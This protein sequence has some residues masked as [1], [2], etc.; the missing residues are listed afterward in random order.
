LAAL[1]LVTILVMSMVGCS[2]RDL[3]VDPKPD[4]RALGFSAPGD[5]TPKPHPT[6]P[7][8][9]TISYPVHFVSADSTAAGSTGTSRWLLG[10]AERKPVDMTW[11]LTA[12]PSWPGFP[13]QGVQHIGPA[14]S[15]TL[16]VG[17][18]VPA[19]AASGFY[20]LSMTVSTT[21]TTTYTDY[22]T[23]RVFGN[24]PPPT[25]PPTPAVAFAGSDSVPP[26]S[27]A[28][29]GWQL[30]NE[31]NHPFTMTWTLSTGSQWP[32]FPT[33]G[34]VNLAAQQQ[35]FILVDVA[36]PD[37]AVVGLRSIEMTVT[38]P[39]SLPP[40]SSPGWIWVIP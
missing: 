3:G 40:Q 38:R 35:Q 24:E 36:V 25:P 26:G 22:G 2:K 11:S 18:P 29:T 31:S 17:V 4:F 8:D 32:G 39:D 10:N 16:S 30:F 28:H 1:A 12:D 37:T 6:P 14:R 33:Q 34:T 9:T 13:I 23:M 7:P 15:V 19:S 5:S 20:T 27:T 21:P